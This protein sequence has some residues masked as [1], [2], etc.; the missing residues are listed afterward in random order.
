VLSTNNQMLVRSSARC[1]DDRL[2]GFTKYQQTTSHLILIKIYILQNITFFGQQNP[3]KK[4]TFWCQFSMVTKH[5]KEMFL[6]GEFA[7]ISKIL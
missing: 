3:N 4:T 1:E 7:F 2:Q 5:K 6:F